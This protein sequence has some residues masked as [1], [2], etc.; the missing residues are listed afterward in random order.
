MTRGDINLAV[1][2]NGIEDVELTRPRLRTAKYVT[3]PEGG[4]ST[5]TVKESRGLVNVVAHYP[6]FAQRG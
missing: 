3:N 6:T 2:N 1:S 4:I 5:P